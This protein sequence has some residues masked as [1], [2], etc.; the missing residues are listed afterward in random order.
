[1]TSRQAPNAR[2]GWMLCWSDGSGNVECNRD[3]LDAFDSKLKREFV[4]ML[5]KEIILTRTAPC[6]PLLPMFIERFMNIRQTKKAF[7][8][9]NDMIKNIEA[10]ASKQRQE[11]LSL[12]RS[13]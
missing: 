3:C 5:H 6:S 12:N 8:R 1:M 11:N 7:N 2:S 4:M 13:G 9:Y 10:A